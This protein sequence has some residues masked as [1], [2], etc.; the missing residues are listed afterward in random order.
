MEHAANPQEA[1]HAGCAGTTLDVADEGNGYA[2][3]L[4]HLCLRDAH[5]FSFESDA[6]AQQRIIHLLQ[7][8]SLLYIKSY[9]YY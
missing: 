6:G 3:A 7:A 9:W 8:P 2:A 5:F 1:L 4:S